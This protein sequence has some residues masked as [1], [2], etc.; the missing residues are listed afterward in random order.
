MNLSAVANAVTDAN[1]IVCDPGGLDRALRR[2]NAILCRAEVLRWVLDE[3]LAAK[4]NDG[5]PSIAATMAISALIARLEA[6]AIGIIVEPFN[7]GL[8]FVP[9]ERELGAAGLPA[10]SVWIG[11]SKRG[12]GSPLLR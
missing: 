5:L 10:G 1:A 4:D 6:G 12:G 7:A 11:G 8:R 2:S 9:G 3:S